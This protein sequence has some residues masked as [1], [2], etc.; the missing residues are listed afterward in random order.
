MRLRQR[1]AD[2]VTHT[3]RERNKEADLWAGKGARGLAEEWVDTAPI[4]WH[5][6]LSICGLWDGSFDNGKCRSG[7]VLMTFSVLQRWYPFYKRCGPVPGN[8][9]MDAEMGGCAHAESVQQLNQSTIE[10]LA[11]VLPP[12]LHFSVTRVDRDRA[13]HR[14]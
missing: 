4:T 8:S 13:H 14:R 6:V 11:C 9:S 7:I 1:T 12:T 2:W 5:E 10:I 3:F